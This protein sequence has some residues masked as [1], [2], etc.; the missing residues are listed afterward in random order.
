MRAALISLAG[1]QAAVAGRPLALRQLD[2]ALAAGATRIFA[3]GDGASPGAFALAHAAER[4]GARCQTIRDARGLLGTL[5]ASDELLVLVPGL[6]PESLEALTAL[7]TPGV[8]T[9]PAA[10][11]VAAGFERID[12][13]R[14]WGGAL[15]IPG[16]LVERLAQLPPDSEPAPALLRIALQGAVAERRLPETGLADG[17]WALAAGDGAA[18]ALGDRWLQRHVRPAGRYALSAR[19]SQAVLRPFALRLL[20]ARRAAQ[21]IG[22]TGL[23]L[24]AGAIALCAWVSPAAGLAVLALGLLYAAFGQQLA[25]LAAGPFA[26]SDAPS[27]ASQ[28]G[29]WLSDAAL[30]ACTAL[31]ISGEPIHRLFAPLI[32]AAA[33]RASGIAGWPNAPALLGDRALLALFFAVAAGF[34]RAEP[35]VMVAALAILVLQAARPPVKFG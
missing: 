9:L 27:R 12:L 22:L 35:A 6:L 19:I 30:V 8:L 25:T 29:S 15:V 2:F 5:R 21:A 11:G 14:A 26:R 16:A 34:G 31:A 4:A 24:H 23:A 20:A 33:L 17:S 18:S 3:I 10:T 28:L 32:L 1:S 7:A 13:E